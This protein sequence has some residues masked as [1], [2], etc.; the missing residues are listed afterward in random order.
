[1]MATTDNLPLAEIDYDRFQEHTCTR[2]DR[3]LTVADVKAALKR[4]PEAEPGQVYCRR[5]TCEALEDKPGLDAS[6][7]VVPRPEAGVV[8]VPSDLADDESKLA[9][10]R[11]E[12]GLPPEKT[13]RDIAEGLRELVPPQQ[14]P[15]HNDPRTCSVCGTDKV[16]NPVP[17][18]NQK[19][20]DRLSAQLKE[21]AW[22]QPYSNGNRSRTVSLAPEPVPEKELSLEE[23][24]QK[25][26]KRR[27]LTKTPAKPSR[28]ERTVLDR[29][30]ILSDK[31]ASLRL[32]YGLS[33]R[34]LADVLDNKDFNVRFLVTDMEFGHTNPKFLRWL[35]EIQNGLG[36]S[37]YKTISKGDG[38]NTF[39]GKVPIRPGNMKEWK[40][41]LP[42]KWV[43]CATEAEKSFYKDYAARNLTVAEMKAKYGEV[44]DENIRL[45]E[46]RIVRR[47][48]YLKLFNPPI[49]GL[50][51]AD[52]ERDRDHAWALEEQAIAKGMAYVGSIFGSNRPGSRKTRLATPPMVR[53]NAN[54]DDGEESGMI[55]DDYGEGSGA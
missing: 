53:S 45:L 33:P 36:K 34:Q 12:Q 52:F 40:N 21:T 55:E 25:I 6:N 20:R 39:D 1:M 7:E 41:M 3:A 22:G 27:K 4:N 19:E 49:G 26:L 48:F 23:E 9:K 31:D 17:F 51:P 54:G 30:N 16:S 50:K 47:G 29:L 28:R 10:I 5:N 15:H 37:R 13:D 11:R 46:N 2:C 44:S 8:T 43:T 38:V 42:S 32:E 14:C 35:R 24:V 18:Q